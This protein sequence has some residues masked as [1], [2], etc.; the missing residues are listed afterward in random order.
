MLPLIRNGT[1]VIVLVAGFSGAALA[2]S[3]WRGT[4]LARQQD[5]ERR[6]WLVS[7]PSEASHIATGRIGAKSKLVRRLIDG[8]LNLLEVAA[9]FRYVNDHPPH[10]R[11]DFRKTTPGCGDVEKTCRQ[12]LAWVEADL[13]TRMP[14]SQADQVLGRFEREL[15]TLLAETGTVELPW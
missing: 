14:R 2:W 5:G 10:H 1:R 13:Q 12:V 6:S 11:C 8:E 4:S 7:A 3:G 9:W 15:D